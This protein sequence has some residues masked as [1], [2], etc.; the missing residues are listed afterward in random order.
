MNVRSAIGAL[1]EHASQ[2]RD[3]LLE[4]VVRDSQA[5]PCRCDQLILRDDRSRMSEQIEQDADVTI[6]NRD[7]FAGALAAC[8]S[9]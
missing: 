8:I 2:S 9:R 3:R 4:A 6:G 7:E 1:A 5:I